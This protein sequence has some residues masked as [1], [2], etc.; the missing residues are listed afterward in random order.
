MPSPEQEDI[1]ALHAQFKAL[2]KTKA[3]SPKASTPP[4]TTPTNPKQTKLKK[5]ANGIPIFEGDA[6]WRNVKPKPG[7]PHTKQVNGEPWYFCSCHGYWAA[8][9]TS[10]CK[11]KPPGVAEGG[12]EITAAL[13]HIGIEDI[14]HSE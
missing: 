4:A 10:A 12:D 14:A 3:N 7:E 6:A 11:S 13:A 1:I 9:L 2:K 5:D 8:H